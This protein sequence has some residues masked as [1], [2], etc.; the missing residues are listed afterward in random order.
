MVKEPRGVGKGA[1][2]GTVRRERWSRNLEG[3]GEGR[4][5]R[6]GRRCEVGTSVS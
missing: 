2:S 3:A 6:V 1:E 5:G 4:E